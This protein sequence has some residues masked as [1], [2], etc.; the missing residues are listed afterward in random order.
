MFD[1]ISE[2]C[3]ENKFPLKFDI[4]VTYF[5]KGLSEFIL[6]FRQFFLKYEMFQANVIKNHE[7]HS[8]LCLIFI[9]IFRQFFLKYVMFQANVIKNHESH[10]ILCLIFFSLE[11]TAYLK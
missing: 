2:F 7:S 9:L 4:Y 10:S 1:Y 8:I 6:I 5:I 3:E 11:E